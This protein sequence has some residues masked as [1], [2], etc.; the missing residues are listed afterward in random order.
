VEGIA[1]DSRSESLKEVAM[2]LEKGKK[3]RGLL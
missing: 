3:E 2:G 1:G